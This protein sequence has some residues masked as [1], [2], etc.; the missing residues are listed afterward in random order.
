MGCQIAII[1]KR[2]P[3][4][5]VAEVMGLVGDVQGKNAIII[6]D[7]IDTAGSMTK[8]AKAVMDAGAKQVFAAC[9]HP[10]LS[11][12]AVHL[13]ENSVLSEVVCM[14]TIQLPAD[15]KTSKIVQLSVG[16]LLAQGLINIIQDRPLSTLFEYQ[17]SEKDEK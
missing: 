15:K 11:G 8:A 2:R 5:N 13:I 9:T 10:L 12:D 14:N 3:S 4:A 7:M 6:D 17:G 1:D 16:K